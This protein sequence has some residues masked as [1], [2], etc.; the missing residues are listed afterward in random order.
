M[1]SINEVPDYD[2][3]T[4]EQKRAFSF[5]CN[6]DGFFDDDVTNGYQLI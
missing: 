5:I 6:N 1:F 2:E 4:D 3:A